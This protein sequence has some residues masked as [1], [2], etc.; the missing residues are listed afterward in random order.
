MGLGV[1]YGFGLRLRVQ[2]LSWL[3]RS[4]V[5]GIYKVR[6]CRGKHF[7]VQSCFSDQETSEEVFI[8]NVIQALLGENY[9]NLLR[10]FVPRKQEE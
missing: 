7:R 8:V 9:E 4:R 6:Q 1:E 3:P 2:A 10:H 5:R